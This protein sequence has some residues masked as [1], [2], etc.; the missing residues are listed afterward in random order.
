MP[1][2]IVRFIEKETKWERGMG[3]DVYGYRVSAWDDEKV[4]K[5]GG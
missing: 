5:I 1:N 2:R 3:S 4:P